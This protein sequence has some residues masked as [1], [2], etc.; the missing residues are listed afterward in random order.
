M[1]T[2]YYKDADQLKIWLTHGPAT[3]GGED[4]AEGITLFYDDQDRIV[5]IEINQASQ[6]ADM[7]VIARDP[8]HV[9]SGLQTGM[10]YT[11]PALADELGLAPRTLRRTIETMRATGQEVGLQQA[12]NAAIVLT[13]DDK[14]HIEQW[15]A[16]HPWGRKKVE[17]MAS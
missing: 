7:S 8:D 2:T 9:K 13:E 14:A 16:D 3:G 10:I 4:V 17:E 12:P 6:R 11:V 1:K 15:R 5:G